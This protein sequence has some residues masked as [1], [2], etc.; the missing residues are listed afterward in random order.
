MDVR[1]RALAAALAVFAFAAAP[2]GAAPGDLDP[3]FSND[4]RVSTLTS[5]DTFVPRAVAVQ[6]DGRIVVAGYS[7]DTGTCGLTGDSSFR[8]VRYTA[9]G[10]LDTDFGMGGMVTTALGAGRSQAYDVLVRPDGRILVGGVASM[11]QSD[12]GSFAL[13][14]YLPDGRI[15]TGFGTGGHVLMRIGHGFDAIS[16]LVTGWGG[17][18]VALGQA[19]DD[20]RD[21][22]ALARFDDDGEPDHTFNSGGSVIVP[23][24]A[25]YAYAA[26]GA[27]LP[28]GR[29]V[30]VGASGR[31]SAVENLRFS[32]AVVGFSGNA[33]PPWLRPVGA[34][35]SYGNAAV[36]LPDGRGIL[37]AGVATERSGHPGM[38]LV[39]TSADGALDR[40]WDGDGT[41]LVRARD[42]SVATD[43]VLEPGGRAVAAGHSSAGQNHAFML[44]RFDGSGALD[45]GFG[46]QG[47]VLTDFPGSTMA[48]ATALARQA[49]G[50][51]VVAGI[52][53]SSGSG[54][55]CGG[56]TAR[57]ALA[58]Y[59]GGDAAPPGP[60][61]ANATL[62]GT[63]AS[64]R[65]AAFVTLPSRLVARHGKVK[66]RV[67][68]LQATRCRGKLSLRRLRM[69]RS[70][71][72]IGSRTIS[73]RGRRAATFT[74][75]LR[76][77]R[78]GSGRRL[79]VRLEL[80]GRDATGATRKVTRNVA[81]RRA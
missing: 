10:G 6:P 30:A 15:D 69:S 9:D 37:S 34:T 73:V 61:P 28:D 14:R 36:A 24:S 74:V 65:T 57:L 64:P 78:L 75:K 11:D 41:A 3:T 48:R 45:R 16:D 76:R 59:Q 32:G 46:R 66:V 39:R 2:A 18:V 54:P 21:H 49:D 38:A 62:P 23:A 47:V 31:S 44:A 50:K 4:G 13:V 27:M 79:R 12:P 81:L 25:P 5:P 55:Q 80:A 60:P 29:I 42:G 20:G 22:F 72:L 53:C 7:C 17:R 26:G 52:A 56:G 40:S 51:L 68:C 71:L 58:R 70:S 77:K 19:Q 67:R 8:V 63:G 33:A 1:K 35:Y 43:V